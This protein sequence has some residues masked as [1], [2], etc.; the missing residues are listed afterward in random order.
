MH[1][2][3]WYQTEMIGQLHAPAYLLPD[4]DPLYPLDGRLVGLQNLSGRCREQKCLRHCSKLNSFSLVLQ[5]AALS[6][7]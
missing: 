7:Y 1:F 6:Q 5:P 4:K 3:P 2:Q